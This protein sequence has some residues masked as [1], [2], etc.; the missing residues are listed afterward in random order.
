MDVGGGGEPCSL[1][2]DQHNG[3]SDF[4]EKHDGYLCLSGEQFQLAKVVNPNIELCARVVF[5]FGSQRDGYWAG[6]RLMGKQRQRV[7]VP[8][9]SIH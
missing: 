6:E 9:S 5:K 4:I 8:S 2:Q 1:A 3:I 7:I